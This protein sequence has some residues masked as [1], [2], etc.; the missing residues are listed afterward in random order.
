MRLGCLLIACAVPLGC[1]SVPLYEGDRDPFARMIDVIEPIDISP[2]DRTGI[3]PRYSAAV[4]PPPASIAK[5]TAPPT[6]PSRRLPKSP[7]KIQKIPSPPP[8]TP[9]VPQ[10]SKTPSPPTTTAPKSPP[11]SVKTPQVR[12]QLPPPSPPSAARLAVAPKPSQSA[13]LDF[14]DAERAQPQKTET[15]LIADPKRGDKRKLAVSAPPS[16]PKE[17]L[18][19]VATAPSQPVEPLAKVPPP[20]TPTPSSVSGAPG[21]LN[22]I[23][24]AAEP[25]LTLDDG[26][27]SARDRGR[28]LIKRSNK[29]SQS[30]KPQA[31]FASLDGASSTEFGTQIGGMARPVG[32]R[33]PKTTR[34]VVSSAKGMLAECYVNEQLFQDDAK[35]TAV[36]VIEI[37]KEFPNR[38]RIETSD[39]SDTMN[40]CLLDAVRHLPFPGDPEGAAYR[41]RIPFRFRPD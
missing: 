29:V 39:F 5:P 41:L 4:P 14:E 25:A 7:Q 35:G 11:Q 8:A 24:S 15:R 37:P 21:A 32:I 2:T 18:P 1:E 10:A 17:K 31:G 6:M 38:P 23:A 20:P 12:P 3:V 30:A 34:K 40:A 22:S 19:N 36:V 26:Q 28:P 16:A 9:V 33:T 13:T 27:P